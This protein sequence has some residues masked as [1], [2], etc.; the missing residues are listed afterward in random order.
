MTEIARTMLD[1]EY[2]RTLREV[3]LATEVNED[4]RWQL[5]KLVK[6]TDLQVKKEE[7]ESKKKDRVITLVKDGIMIVISIVQVGGSFY[8]MA[9]SMKF[10]ETGTFTSKA[11]RWVGDHFHWPNWKK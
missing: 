1:E 3:S 9:K 8:W 11:W 7:I 10:E 5:E 4:A 6:L 2:E